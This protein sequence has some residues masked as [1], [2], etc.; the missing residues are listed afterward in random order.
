MTKT[1]KFIIMRKYI[2]HINR[3][4]LI[5]RKDYWITYEEI[6]KHYLV[7]NNPENRKKENPSWEL[8]KEQKTELNEKNKLIVEE[9]ESTQDKEKDDEIEL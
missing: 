4:A 9:L 2:I 8:S 3:L 5:L 1:Q 7:G 6:V